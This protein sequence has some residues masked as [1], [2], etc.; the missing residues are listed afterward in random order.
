MK[1]LLLQLQ[2]ELETIEADSIE[3]VFIGGGTPSTIAAQEYA[4]V[5]KM[6]E[7]YLQE[8]SEVTIEANPNSATLEWMKRVKELGVNRI[9]FGVQSFDESKLKLLN[10]AHTPQMAQD[11]IINAEKIGFQNISLDLIYNVAGD[12]Q[13]LLLRDIE[14][15]FRL[16]INHISAYELTIEENTLFE[17]T[18]QMRV[19]N[20][21]IAYLIRDEIGKRGFRQYEV[22]NYGIYQSQHNLGY[23]QLKNYI[24]VGAG[25]V[26]FKNN[27][28]LYPHSNL[29]A[30]LS[31]PLHK[32]IEELHHEEYLLEKIFLGLRSSI[33][34]A[35]KILPFTMQKK[36]MLLVKERKLQI[37]D[38]IYYNQDYL[39]SDEIALYITA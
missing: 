20:L 36:A 35:D 21:E 27:K 11:A 9:S 17:K 24:G 38:G 16:P 2:H 33:G 15:A 34:V 12:T 39:L 1:A 37:K 8:G 18:P 4:V 26:G 19:D 28:R 10:R 32:S 22:S 31:N 25:A 5:F 6:L 29:D 3:S 23:W 14:H 30:Y 7:G 13:A